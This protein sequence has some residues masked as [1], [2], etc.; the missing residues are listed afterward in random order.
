MVALLTGIHTSRVR[1]CSNGTRSVSGN[2]GEDGTDID[3]IWRSCFMLEH[4]RQKGDGNVG[5]LFYSQIN[6]AIGNV[7]WFVAKK[8]STAGI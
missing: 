3:H 1:L 8:P 6:I 5:A 2:S 4:A 7:N